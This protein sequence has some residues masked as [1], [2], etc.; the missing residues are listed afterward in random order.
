MLDAL[1]DQANSITLRMPSCASISSKPRLTSSS[2]M[3]CETNGSTSISPASA[4]LDELGHLVA[5]LDA[6]ER[7][8]RDAPAGDEEA[9]DDVERLALARRR[10]RPCTAPSPCAPTRPPGASRSRCPSPRTC[11]RRRSRRSARGSASTASGPPTSV[12]VAPWPARARAVSG[13]RSTQT[14]RSAP[15]RRQ[16]ATAP[17]PTMPGAEDDAGRAGLDL[18]RVHRRA[19]PGREAA[20]EEARVLERRLG[21]DLRQRDLR[22]DRVLGERRACP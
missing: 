16:P 13:E 3:R 7:R 10:P 12:S 15:C 6:A 11:S 14:I 2:V 5:A 17:S 1:D 18:R 9:R 21:V 8:A 4:A 19:E 20:G 22:H